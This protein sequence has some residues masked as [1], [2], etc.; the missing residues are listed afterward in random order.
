VLVSSHF[1]DA[2]AIQCT[3]CQLLYL[4]ARVLCIATLYYFRYMSVEF[5]STWLH[6]TLVLFVFILTI[7]LHVYFLRVFIL[8]VRRRR[9]Q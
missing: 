8:F 1:S 5:V 9:Y 3:S 7:D 6:L 2:L 4:T